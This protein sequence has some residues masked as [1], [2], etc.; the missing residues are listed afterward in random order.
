MEEKSLCS[1]AVTLFH[2][3]GVKGVTYRIPALLYIPPAQVLLAFVEKRS[4]KCDT[5]ALYLVLRRGQKVN[6]SVQWGPQESL[7]E[8][9]LPGFRTM[10]PCPVWEKKSGRVFLFFI[11]IRNHV[12]E[13]QQICSGRNAAR[14]CF[15][16]S[17]DHGR[18][19]SQI[20]DLTEEVIG[21]E[22][23]R[24]ATFAV[25]PGHG[26]Q[27]QSGRLVIPAYAYYISG[28]HCL[29]C[30]FSCNIKPHSLMFY[31][32]DLGATWKHGQPIHCGETL[33][34]QVAEVMSSDGCSVLYCNSRTHDKCRVEA[35]SLDLG[36]HFLKPSPVPKLK[37]PY[38]GCQGSVVSFRTMRGLQ[39]EEAPDDVGNSSVSSQL[40]S[41]V[42]TP[43][44]E[45]NGSQSLSGLL[46]SHP[47]DKRHRKN[48]GV[49][50]KEG[51]LEDVIW[52]DPF[53]IYK[54][55]SGYSDLAVFETDSFGCLFECGEITEYERVDFLVLSSQDIP[56]LNQ[57][58][59]NHFNVD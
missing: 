19:W 15:V 35:L 58:R 50:M 18:S 31:S 20:R 6:Q 33:E 48:L 17:S 10:N 43:G 49:Y 25:G 9:T 12:S 59:A 46:Y 3:E 47:T 56:R 28:C 51:Y 53:I 34:C 22:V 27:L 2:Q 16:S 45:Q 21:D 40:E 7:V 11:C 29:G 8:A 52:S 30:P 37:E 24:W 26:I 55:P 23:E 41:L 39:G 13:Q 36:E 5:D 32:D 38:H 4:T 44:P 14:L 57:E 42:N 54:G 1:S